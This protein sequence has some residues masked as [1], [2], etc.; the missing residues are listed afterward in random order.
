[1]YYSVEN[2]LLHIYYSRANHWNDLM[3]M[4]IN[5]QIGRQNP[6]RKRRSR[7]S[8]RAI[9][10]VRRFAKLNARKIT[11]LGNGQYPRAYLHLLERITPLRRISPSFSPWSSKSLGTCS[12][13]VQSIYKAHSSKAR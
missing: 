12:K 3:Y 5:M 2:T 4:N 9:R 10:A 11:Q 1:M 7:P 6:S 8:I 13:I